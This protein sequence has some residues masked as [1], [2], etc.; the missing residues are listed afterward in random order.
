MF[1]VELQTYLIEPTDFH[2]GQPSVN[3]TIQIKKKYKLNC[4]M[5]YF[6]SVCSLTSYYSLLFFLGYY[7]NS[8]ECSLFKNLIQ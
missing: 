5:K 6:L 7:Y 8:N 1:P 3:T 4:F 2:P